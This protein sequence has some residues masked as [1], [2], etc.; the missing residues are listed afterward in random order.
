M[1]QCEN[2]DTK[3]KERTINE[4][5]VQDLQ[6]HELLGGKLDVCMNK[7]TDL[8][9]YKLLWTGADGKGNVTTLNVPNNN[10]EGFRQAIVTGWQLSEY[11]RVLE[12]TQ[13][14]SSKPLPI[15]PQPMDLEQIR[16]LARMVSSELLELIQTRTSGP[17]EAIEFL[18]NCVSC[19]DINRSYKKPEDLAELIAE[20]LDAKVD[21]RY[22]I[23]NDACKF[24]TNT[25]EGFHIAHQANM[26]K[27]WPD[28]SFHLR[29]DGKIIKPPDWKEPDMVGYIRKKLTEV[30]KPAPIE[31]LSDE[32]EFITMSLRQL[33]KKKHKLLGNSAIAT[34]IPAASNYLIEKTLSLT[35]TNKII[36]HHPNFS[37]STS[38]LSEH[39]DLDGVVVEDRLGFLPEQW[40]IISPALYKKTKSVDQNWAELKRPEKLISNE[41]SG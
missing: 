18:H 2:T 36:E 39:L 8:I 25:N 33:V 11:A 23:D 16:F 28:G 32:D 27:R 30:Q 13:G 6:N 34:M 19:A 1:N 15:V 9:V 31:K 26:N 12:F 37:R 41:N 10:L 22:Y 24:A 3:E 17:D 4:L 40:K 35:G 20:Q 38:S 14:A 7:Y 21:M 29:P 5:D